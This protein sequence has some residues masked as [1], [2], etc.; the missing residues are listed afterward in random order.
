MYCGYQEIRQNYG[1]APECL[2]RRLRVL[3]TLYA[4]P[5]CN[6]TFH[7]TLSFHHWVRQT[8]YF[9][10]LSQGTDLRIYLQR[11]PSLS[12]TCTHYKLMEQGSSSMKK[13]DFARSECRYVLDTN[14]TQC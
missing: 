8:V 7:L 5:Y 6:I 3:L 9:Q 4:T 12:F 10:H 14:R 13:Y 1:K 2:P 11:L